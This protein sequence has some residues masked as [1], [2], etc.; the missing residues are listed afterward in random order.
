MKKE[1]KTILVLED[2]PLLIDS[3]SFKLNKEGYNFVVKKVADEA[4]A[5]VLENPP[6]DF[7]WIDHYLIG[8]ENGLFFLSRIK[9][10][11]KFAHIPTF[12]VSNTASPDTIEKYKKIGITRYYTKA[13]HR[14]DEIVADIGTLLQHNQK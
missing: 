11:P 9:Q 12:V 4:L 8:K 1:K 5:Y 7:F 10:N 13:N 3:I 6:P 14:L 2:E